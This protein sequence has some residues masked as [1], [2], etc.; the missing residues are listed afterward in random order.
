MIR[1]VNLTQSRSRGLNLTADILYRTAVTGRASKKVASKKNSLD[2]QKAKL[3]ARIGT[4][5]MVA[6]KKNPDPSKNV[7]LARALKE[8]VAVKLPKDNIERALKKAS[9]ADTA[10]FVTTTY[11][12]FGFGGCGIVVRSL[13]DNSNRAVKMI[14]AAANKADVKFGN[15][16]VLHLFE[17]KGILKPLSQSFDDE[18]I[19]EVALEGGIDELDFQSQADV[20][21]IVTAPS[22]LN[23]LQDLLSSAGIET[24]SEFWYIAADKI[25]MKDS[26]RLANE[27]L[28]QTLEEIEDVDAV[29]HN[30]EEIN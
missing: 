12:L 30:M 20:P 14:K 6:A 2:D 4:K 21:F 27:K 10:D 7:D 25:A 5:I 19:M 15:G 23:H 3:F 24:S 1:C 22:S 11:D 18:K 17:L 13:T 26:D 29:F 8:A 9:A 16:S 28:I